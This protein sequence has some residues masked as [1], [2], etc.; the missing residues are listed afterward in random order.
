[1][2]TYPEID[3]TFPHKYSL[4][5]HSMCPSTIRKLKAVVDFRK[6][7]LLSKCKLICFVTILP[8]SLKSW[9]CKHYHIL[10][11]MGTSSLETRNIKLV[12]RNHSPL[13]AFGDAA[14]P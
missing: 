4:Y 10:F 3:G 13:L 2:S 7:F 1:M 12:N 9:S 11:N 5:L 8:I 6:V 14:V